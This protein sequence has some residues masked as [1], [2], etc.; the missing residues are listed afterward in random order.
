MSNVLALQS[1]KIL[2]M[3]SH[4]TIFP[5]QDKAIFLS[6]DGQYTQTMLL[7]Q[8]PVHNKLLHEMSLMGWVLRNKWCECF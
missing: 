8:A 1:L 5:T 6:V 4:Q 3:N 2:R 7:W